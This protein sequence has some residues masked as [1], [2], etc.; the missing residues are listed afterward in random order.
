MVHNAQQPADPR[1]HSPCRIPAYA[2]CTPG[3]WSPGKIGELVPRTERRFLTDQSKYYRKKT[4][5]IATTCPLLPCSFCLYLSHMQYAA[6]GRGPDK[7]NKCGQNCCRVN[8][9]LYIGKCLPPRGG[10]ISADVTWGKNLKRK[11]EKEGN[12]RKSKKE[13][14]KGREE[15]R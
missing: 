3:T 13:E 15:E 6:G 12:G 11:K 4:V 8:R 10:G 1:T 9:G 14:R 5:L 7:N 2:T